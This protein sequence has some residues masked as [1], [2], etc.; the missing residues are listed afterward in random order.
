M[1]ATASLEDLKAVEA[2]M[3]EMEAKYPDAYKWLVTAL[4]RHKNV[5][6]KNICKMILGVA[7]EQ[8]KGLK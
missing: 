2:D 8:L 5:G 3:R 7:A 1:P 4:A 6:W